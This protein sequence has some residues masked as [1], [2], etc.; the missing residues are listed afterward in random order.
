MQKNSISNKDYLYSIFLEAKSIPDKTLVNDIVYIGQKA[1]ILNSTYKFKISSSSVA[2]PYSLD[3][4]RDLT[5]FIEYGFINDTQNSDSL[6]LTN[7]TYN[8]NDEPN[9][10]K[11]LQELLSID[12]NDLKILGSIL[13]L[14]EKFTNKGLN[15]QKK[16]TED[17]AQRTWTSVEDVKTG[18]EFVNNL[19]SL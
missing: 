8:I 15:D 12:R 3:L 13:I 1:K 5:F 9:H 7:Q 11:G 10:K 16:R 2:D 14:E 18:L 17:I 6:I 4:M 19:H